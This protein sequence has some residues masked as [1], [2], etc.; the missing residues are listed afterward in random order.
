[1]AASHS[2][3]AAVAYYRMSSDKQEASIPEQRKAVERFAK[4]HGYRI[5]SEYI[6]EGISGWKE[7]R[8]GFQ[9]LITDLTR[10][11]FQAV[12][13]WDQN[14]FSRF[15]VLEAN[16]YWFLLD[17][18]GVHLATVNQGRLDWHSIAGWLTASIKQYGD[19][20]HRHQLSADVKRGKRARAERGEW[21]GKIP[22]AYTVNGTRKLMHGDAHEVTIVR[23]V[24]A[25]YIGGKSIRHVCHHLN[26]AGERSRSGNEWSPT[27]V[28]K[29]LTNLAYIGTYAHGDV[30]IEGNHPAI[31]DR[32]TFDTVQRLLTERQP[33]TTPFMG[34]GGYL[35]TGLLRCGE[36]GSAMCGRTPHSGNQAYHCSG[37]TSKGASYCNRNTVVQAELAERVTTAVAE[38]FTNPSV[39][40]RLRD[41]LHRQVKATTGKVNVERTR[42]QL[43]AVD[44]KLVKA[45]R[46]L[47]E[48]DAD[49]L[50]LV[51]DHLR[52]LQRQRTELQA[53]LDA[54]RTPA[55]ALR[56]AAD[57]SI[58]AAVSL[59]ARL[60]ETLQRGDTTDLRGLL[61]ETIETVEVWTDKRPHGRLYQFDLA[62]GV[63]HLRGANLFPWPR[64][65]V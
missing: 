32:A 59:F 6:D 27:T 51:Q 40:R 30:V 22:Y 13:C 25:E 11:D 15:P 12:L 41:E 65:W 21:Q 54:T 7:E 36:C 56:S 29:L 20:Q 52:D 18:A 24:Y 16:H 38:R 53:A 31:I 64:R 44:E 1:M 42:K 55:D 60:P 4:E 57:E 50:P 23:R 45:K 58:D 14:R 47:V 39:L 19:A 26:A 34:G 62:R 43:T 9:R 61:R 17:R 49:M 48:V 5:L 46:R 10:G 33:L 37:Y 28:N 63:V 3:I 8:E 35:F 2:T